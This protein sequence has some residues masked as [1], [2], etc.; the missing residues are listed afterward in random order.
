M[1]KNKDLFYVDDVMVLLKLSKD[2]AYKKIR[3]LNKEL[4]EKGYMVRRG[5]VSKAYFVERYG[6]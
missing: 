6:L 2:A 5:A 3:E 4:K 1:E